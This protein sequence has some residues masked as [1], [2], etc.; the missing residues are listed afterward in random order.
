MIVISLTSSLSE[1]DANCTSERLPLLILAR[2]IIKF[3]SLSDIYDFEDD[4]LAQSQFTSTNLSLSDEILMS[5]EL[6]R[7]DDF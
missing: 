6:Q 2:Q 7:L 5:S 1:S 4:N 3:S